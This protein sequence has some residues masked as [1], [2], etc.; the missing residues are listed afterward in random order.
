MWEAGTPLRRH[1]RKVT[2]TGA[3]PLF[4]Q[5]FPVKSRGL[6]LLRWKGRQKPCRSCTTLPTPSK[7][8]LADPSLPEAC[9]RLPH[10]IALLPAWTTPLQ[11]AVPPCYHRS[12]RGRRQRERT[13]CAPRAPL[14]APA[15][16]SGSLSLQSS[17][18][19]GEDEDA[20]AFLHPSSYRTLCGRAWSRDLRKPHQEKNY[21]PMLYSLDFI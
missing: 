8:D 6:I 12:A 17:L 20:P 16:C 15:D 3:T 19:R 9:R 1:P 5:I 18:S 11:P 2:R 14:S 10:G 7:A 4:R 13:R 21:P